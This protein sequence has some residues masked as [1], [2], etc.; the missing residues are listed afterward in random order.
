MKK[1][2]ITVL[3][4]ALTLTLLAGCENANA[5]QPIGEMLSIDRTETTDDAGTEAVKDINVSEI[6]P[7]EV[8]PIMSDIGFG[9]Q[10]IR[11]DGYHSEAKYP[12]FYI[13]RSEADI[14]SYYEQNKELYNLERRENH[15]SDYTIGFLDACD[16]Y[17]GDFFKTKSLVFV[18]LEEGSGSIRHKVTSV[19]GDTDSL[20]VD[21]EKNVPFCCSDD[22]A[23]WHI[24]IELEN[25][26]TPPDTSNI[27]VNINAVYESDSYEAP[28]P[29]S[30]EPD[31]E[32]IADIKD[33]PTE[34]PVDEPKEPDTVDE[35]IEFN[36]KAIQYIRTDGFYD[37]TYSADIDSPK[38]TVICSYGELQ[39]YL[40]TNENEHPD[41]SC[42]K[43]IEKG[44][45][46][47]EKSFFED[48]ALLVIWLYEGSGSISHEVTSLEF[49]DGISLE[50]TRYSPEC[51][52]CDMAQHQIIIELDKEQISDKV[53]ISFKEV[54][55]EW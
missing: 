7:S 25:K 17:D 16:K 38:T 37:D 9:V 34:K 46:V 26:Q 5:D 23:E 28:L 22:M 6:T 42:A 33:T 2:I 3:L 51:F 12:A 32:P 54:D 19:K 47:Y 49:N 43:S 30:K 31:D 13:A 44:F 27:E 4:S 18:L 36:G 29:D 15:Y 52:T 1:L 55:V 20:I 39:A 24:I 14:E 21:I 50:I 10:Y 40:A 48:K 8:V 45:G 41:S 11:T 35:P 53:D